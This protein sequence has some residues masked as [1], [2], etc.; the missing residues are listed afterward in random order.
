MKAKFVFL[1]P[2]VDLG[3]SQLTFQCTG[4]L[5]KV[6]SG[7]MTKITHSVTKEEI[8]PFSSC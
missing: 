6:I 5:Y 8:E 1:Q 3:L 7:S 4:A 2:Q